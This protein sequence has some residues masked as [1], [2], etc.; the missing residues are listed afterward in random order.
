MKA[1]V[2]KL[3]NAP[4]GLEE[5]EKLRGQFEEVKLEVARLSDH[6]AYTE[7]GVAAW[8]EVREGVQVA[9][10]EVATL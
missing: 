5:V 6:P 1:E 3:M 4:S 2:I 7:G 10:E 9:R 8:R